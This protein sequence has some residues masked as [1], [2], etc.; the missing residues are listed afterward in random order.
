MSIGR[1]CR[2]LFCGGIRDGMGGRGRDGGGVEGKERQSYLNSG[3]ADTV[4]IMTVS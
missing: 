2:S 3:I 4:P 1:R